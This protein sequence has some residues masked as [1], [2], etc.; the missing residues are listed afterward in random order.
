MRRRIILVL[1]TILSI[2]SVFAQSSFEQKLL[3]EEW[4]YFQ[5]DS[6]SLRTVFALRKTNLFFHQNEVDER[7][8]YEIKRLDNRYVPE[9]QKENLYWNVALASYLLDE[10]YYYLKYA[11]RYK[12]L[13]G[14]TVE[15]DLLEFLVHV[16]LN[17]T[18]SQKMLDSLQAK[19]SAFSDLAYLLEANNHESKH[20]NLV[21]VMAKIIPGSGLLILKKPVKGVTSMALNTATVF[22][23]RYLIQNNMYVNTFAWG[24]NLIQRF[25]MGGIALTEK[26]IVEKEAKEK[27]H[28]ALDGEDALLN[29]LAKYP[30]VFRN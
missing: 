4:N 11:N 18:E 19:D 20:K 15:M 30:L 10:R 21:R 9:A 2:N 16:K 23:L 3:E 7:L 27:A 6:D 14:S 17:E 25:Y 26:M 5:A 13:A 8:F 12:E 24:M 22:A 29:V 1:L 28:L